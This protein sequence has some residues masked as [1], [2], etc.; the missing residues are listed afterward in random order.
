MQGS[1][2]ANAERAR[3]EN[4]YPQFVQVAAQKSPERAW[5]VSDRRAQTY[6]HNNVGSAQADGKKDNLQQFV[7]CIKTIASA[8]PHSVQAA[9]VLHNTKALQKPVT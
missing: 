6:F 5:N 2:C 9:A 8:R 4:E 7:S 1:L 3:T